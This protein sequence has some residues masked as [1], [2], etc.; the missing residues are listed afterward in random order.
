MKRR[1]FGLACASALLVACGGGPARYPLAPPLTKDPDD[2]PFSPAPEEY[3]APYEWDG[4]NETIF[5]PISRFFAVD[6]AGRAKNVNAYDEVPDSSWFVNRIGKKA[7]SVAEMKRGACDDK[8]LDPKTAKKG[9]W[10]IDQGKPNG[11]NPGFRVNIPGYGKFMLKTD[12]A[13]EPDRATGA[14]AVA[15][16]LYHAI[17]YFSPC[18]SVVYFDPSLLTLKPGLT[19]TGNGGESKPFD[20][21]ALD[22]VLKAA[23]TRDGLTRMV[24]S[25]WLPGK[26]I[27]PYKYDGTR[28][29]DPNDVV[30]H[31][32]RREIRA[33]RLIAA[34]TNHFDTREAN[35]MNV[36]L[37]Q[38][39]KDP[40]SPGHVQHYII[41]L[42]D[43]FGS[44][45]QWKEWTKRLGFAYYVDVPYILEDFGSLGTID[46]PWDHA[47][48][49]GGTFKY[50]SARDFD[51]EYWRSGYPNAA[52]VKMTEQDGAWFAR[53]LARI[54]DDLVEAAVDVGAYTPEDSRYLSETL[55]NRRDAILRRYLARISP[56]AEPHL[57]GDALCGTDLARKTHVVPD[58]QKA[59]FATLYTG[60]KLA[61]KWRLAPDAAPGGNVC[62][63]LPHVAPDGGP[64]A[65]DASRYVV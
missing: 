17:G 34:W 60:P 23:S 24:A 5:R 14:T 6:P 38:N 42:G 1:I 61:P 10:I 50:F 33:A 16:R 63:S 28:D 30:D 25:K 58:D 55:I 49:T 19:V 20:Q 32:D 27:G 12:L 39:P 56:I 43:C 44:V 22:A 8:V 7:M 59:F 26:T 37:S 54:T 36:F 18:D 48:E 47:Q 31:E 41:D 35:T 51:P 64:R 45:W 21:K 40:R 53:I 46:R 65:D 52:F 3:D 4:I 9:E 13:G 15:S 29:D 57:E 62:V 11:A 2:Q